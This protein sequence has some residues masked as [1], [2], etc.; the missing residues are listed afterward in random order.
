MGRSPLPKK[1]VMSSDGHLTVICQSSDGHQ[2]VIRWLSDGHQTI[3][4]LWTEN[5]CQQW[6]LFLDS[7]KYLETLKGKILKYHCVCCSN[8]FLTVSSEMSRKFSIFIQDCSQLYLSM[9]SAS[10][11]RVFLIFCKV[12]YLVFLS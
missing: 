2:T 8:S 4:R 3:C 11:V 9:V 1:L 6:S 7:Y 10:K 5:N 12:M